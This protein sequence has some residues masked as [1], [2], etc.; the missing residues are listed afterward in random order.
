[1]DSKTATEDERCGRRASADRR[2]R[3]EPITHSDR[4]KGE[5]RSGE[6]RRA[7]VRR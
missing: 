7:K 5:R 3:E 2:L 1:M 6:D 4:R